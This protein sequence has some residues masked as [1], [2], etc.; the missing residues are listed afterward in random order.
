MIMTRNA[1]ENK[2]KATTR[3][4]TAIGFKGRSRIVCIMEILSPRITKGTKRI[5]IHYGKVPAGFFDHNIFISNSLIEWLDANDNVIGN[6]KQIRQ[7]TYAVDLDTAYPP[8]GV[9]V[10]DLP[11]DIDVAED[12]ERK[13]EMAERDAAE[14]AKKKSAE[15]ADKKAAPKGPPSKKKEPEEPTEDEEGEGDEEDEE[16]DEE[17]P[18]EDEE[19]GEELELTAIHNFVRFSR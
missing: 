14:Q 1:S 17:E 7:S 10:N 13:E 9:P 2:N 6:G 16:G 12:E 11:S 8:V 15:N 4:K 5:K 18:T 19:G 3:L